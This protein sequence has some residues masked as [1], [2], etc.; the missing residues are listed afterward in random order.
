M[1]VQLS[2]KAALPAENVFRT[3]SS[4]KPVEAGFVSPSSTVFF[5]HWSAASAPP[6]L[7]CALP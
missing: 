2:A 6:W 1:Y 7:N 4:R 5:I 3:S